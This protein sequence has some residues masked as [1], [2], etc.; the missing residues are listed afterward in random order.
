MC[1][2]GF[3]KEEITHAECSRRNMAVQDALYVLNGKWKLPIIIAL[4]EG[5]K[6]FTDI[7]RAVS[8]ITPKV[9]SKELKEMELNEFIRRTV[10][11]TVP[12]TVAYELTPYSA[13]LDEVIGALMKWGMQ[14]RERMKSGKKQLAEAEG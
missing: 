2:K 8:G 11:S 1:A 7:Q 9:L 4:S 12:V 5:N 14:H 13:S 6:R 10:Y 3:K